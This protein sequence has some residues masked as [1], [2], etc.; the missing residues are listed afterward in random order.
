[1]EKRPY[2]DKQGNEV[3]F[4]AKRLKFWLETVPED[5]RRLEYGLWRRKRLLFHSNLFRFD[6]KR[7]AGR[8]TTKPPYTHEQEHIDWQEF[9][10]SFLMGQERR[11]RFQEIIQEVERDLPEIIDRYIGSVP[12][13]KILLVALS[14]SS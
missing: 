4:E 11:E 2:L 5:V 10:N 14:G 9:S 7:N 13:D 6:H 3:D 1:M 8:F 12:N